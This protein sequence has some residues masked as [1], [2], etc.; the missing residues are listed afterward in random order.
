MRRSTSILI[1]AWFV[2]ITLVPALLG[3]AGVRA[4]ARDNRELRS[5]P[6][7]SPR[8]WLDPDTWAQVS[9]ALDDHLPGRDQALDAR[10][11]IDQDVF[12]DSTNPDVL[13]GRDDWLFLTDSYNLVC[14]QSM[15]PAQL[16]DRAAR[17]RSLGEE[18]GTPVTV[19]LVPD[20]MWVAGDA[21]GASPGRRCADERRRALRAANAARSAPPIVDSW[22]DFE[23]SDGEPLF[24]KGDSHLSP[25]GERLM[26]QQL[27]DA[28]SPGLFDPSEV[29]GGPVVTG[30]ADLAALLGQSFTETA[31]SWRL[32]RP[33]TATTFRRWSSDGPPPPAWRP[34]GEL[35]AEELLHNPIAEFRTT[36]DAPVVPGT[37][38]VIHDS[39][40]DKI[41]DRLAPFFEHVVFVEY[42]DFGSDPP[43]AVTEW[44]PTADRIIIE[45][46]ERAGYGRLAGGIG[47]MVLG[48][49]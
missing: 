1:T 39:Q 19:Y 5:L 25:A 8:T 29:S 3:L 38:L 26:V 42:A 6:K 10:R 24:W 9:G 18:A 11:V 17:L 48:E 47:R 12:G 23:T 36:G 45:T 35:N 46:V 43:P 21:L 34:L 44:V 33:G 32:E 15:T 40:V 49:R 13:R 16:V 14:Y 27:I 28:I 7:L 2:V 31:A 4:S 37:T 22:S 20:K 30:R 41:L